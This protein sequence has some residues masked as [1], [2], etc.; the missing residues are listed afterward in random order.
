[1]SEV[2]KSNIAIDLGGKYTGLVSYTNTISQMPNDVSAMIINMPEQGSK[3]NNTKKN[4]KKMNYTVKDRTAVRHHTRAVDRFKKARKLIFLVISSAINRKLS[5]KEQEAIASL[6]KR[7]GY[8]RLETEIDIDVLKGVPTSFFAENL[9]G[10]IEDDNCLYDQFLLKSGQVSY[11]K[12]F[13]ETVANS[14]IEILIN[15]LKDKSE[16]KLIKK[17]LMQ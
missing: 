17:P 5:S 10:L 15:S 1:M 14:Q 11:A 12:K 3:K 4:N 6:L 7:R 13:K 9:K 2:L 16:K 8:T